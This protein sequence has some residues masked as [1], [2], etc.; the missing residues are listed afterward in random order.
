M[1]CRPGCGACCIAPSISTL[2][3]PAGR[4]CMHLTPEFRCSL[5]ASTR[6]PCLL[7]RLATFD[8]N[9]R[10]RPQRR[11]GLAGESGNGD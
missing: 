9:V 4:P 10:Q 7:F 8:R 5:F 11:A 1:N 2:D 6:R 3:K